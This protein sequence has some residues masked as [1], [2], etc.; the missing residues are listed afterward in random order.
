MPMA[1]TM[2]MKNGTMVM[3][4]GKVKMKNGKTMLLKNGQCVDMNGTI[5]M[6]PMKKK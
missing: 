1:K 4:D 6:M 2:T 5:T 3:A